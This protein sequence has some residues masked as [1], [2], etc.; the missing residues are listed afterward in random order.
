MG[1]LTSVEIDSTD[2]TIEI[3]WSKTGVGFGVYTL[4][5]EDGTWRADSE[6]MDS[7]TDKDFLMSL[8]TKF[9]EEVEVVS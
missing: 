2:D 9:I 7:G 8:F 3:K 4:Y 6:Y 1:N 5:K